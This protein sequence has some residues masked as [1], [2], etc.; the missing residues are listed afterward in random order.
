MPPQNR[1][2][3]IM[4]YGTWPS[5]EKHPLKKISYINV[6]LIY[7][8]ASQ[9]LYSSLGH[10]MSDMYKRCPHV[11]RVAVKKVR[12]FGLVCEQDCRNTTGPIFS[13]SIKLFHFF[14]ASLCWCSISILASAALLALTNLFSSQRNRSTVSNLFCKSHDAVQICAASMYM[15]VWHTHTHRGQSETR[16]FTWCAPK[17]EKLTA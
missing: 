14:R 4:S 6:Y 2:V 17:T 9:S 7:F 5:G 11:H 13:S 16:N 1:W 10:M 15:W 12:V 3:H 8:G